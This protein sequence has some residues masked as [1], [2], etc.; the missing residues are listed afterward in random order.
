MNNTSSIIINLQKCKLFSH[1][2]EEN[3]KP[4]LSNSKSSLKRYGTN[5]IIF[6]EDEQCKHLSVILAG[7]I[8]IQK[9]DSD[10]NV[11]VVSTIETGNVF[12][13]NLLFGDRNQYPMSV[14]CKEPSEVL[15]I[16][17]EAVYELCEKDHVFMLKL[18]RIL[19]NKAVALS[20]KLKQV[21]MK[22]LRQMI[23]HYLMIIYNKSENS[24]IELNMTKKEWSDKLGVQ[25]PSLSRE[26]IKMKEE[27]LIDYDRKSIK[28]LD[29]EAIEEQS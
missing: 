10:G 20:S 4:I 17:K 25:R 22:S 23:C 28:I 8:D 3:L 29:I 13:E 15:H 24:L 12:G 11:L 6:I 5:D 18:F 7:K 26:L 27:G 19:S 21:S 16:A 1:F 2:T 9:F 14:I